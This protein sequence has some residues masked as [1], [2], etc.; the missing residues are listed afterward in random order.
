VPPPPAGGGGGSLLEGCFG[1]LDYLAGSCGVLYQGLWLKTSVLD[2][3]WEG[4]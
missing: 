2:L 1:G 4:P 3:R